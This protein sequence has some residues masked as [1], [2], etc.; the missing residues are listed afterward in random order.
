MWGW[1][2]LLN[3]QSR[4]GLNLTGK[5]YITHCFQVCFSAGTLCVA[6]AFLYEI[7]EIIVTLIGPKPLEH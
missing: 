4:E 7:Q 5:W 6:S 3:L 2:S 1:L